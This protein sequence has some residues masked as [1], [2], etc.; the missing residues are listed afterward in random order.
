MS[1]RN[2]TWMCKQ[3]KIIEEEEEEK[4]EGR[5]N[6]LPI[7]IW[8]I[9]FE[10]V[11]TPKVIFC[12]ELLSVC[13]TWNK[14]ILTHIYVPLIPP[15]VKNEWLEELFER[16]N[17]AVLHLY[18]ST[19]IGTSETSLIQQS[20]IASLFRRLLMNLRLRVL[21]YVIYHD[22]SS[23]VP[24]AISKTKTYMHRNHDC[25]SFVDMPRELLETVAIRKYS[26]YF[27]EYT[28]QNIWRQLVVR[29]E[30]L[31]ILSPNFNII[32]LIDARQVNRR[33]WCER[34]N[35]I[36]RFSEFVLETVQILADI[37]SQ[38]A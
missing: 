35:V 7:E 24:C 30:E 13:K 21:S 29:I 14:I 17:D 2:F 1:L 12:M 16:S 36:E 27:L 22:S 19:Y 26:D 32:M 6:Q 11:M 3:N 37:V 20:E 5:W 28:M 31:F 38:S 15:E 25:C 18:Q 8:V 9:I 33:P 34:K 4:E 10:Y 23:I